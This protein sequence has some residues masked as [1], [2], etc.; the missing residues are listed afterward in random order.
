MTR[1][2][3]SQDVTATALQV[4]SGGGHEIVLHSAPYIDVGVVQDS[5]ADATFVPS[6]VRDSNE[7][8]GVSR[9]FITHNTTIMY[10]SNIVQKGENQRRKLSE[11]QNRLA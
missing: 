11:D 5:W 1:L 6:H 7:D 10:H 9:W 8:D 4:D 2:L 3:S